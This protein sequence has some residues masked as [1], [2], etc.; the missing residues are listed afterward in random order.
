MNHIVWEIIG[1]IIVLQIF[2]HTLINIGI[3][4]CMNKEMKK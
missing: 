1:F 2:I 4:I 3:K